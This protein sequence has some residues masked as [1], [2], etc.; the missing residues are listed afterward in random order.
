G[1]LIV[2][3]E[4]VAIRPLRLE[5]PVEALHLAVLPRAMGSDEDVAS[6]E[7]VE[8]ASE[9]P[10]VGIGPGVVGHDGSDG[11]AL[12]GQACD[13]SLEEGGGGGALLVGE[14][15]GVGITTVVVDD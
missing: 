5:R 4:D 11:D 10:A 15:L 7:A 13:R 8:G 1:A 12:S 3:R 6:A 9:V 14:D 2:A